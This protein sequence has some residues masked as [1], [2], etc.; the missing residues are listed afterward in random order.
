MPIKFL[1]LS[2]TGMRRIL[3]ASIA[4]IATVTSS[5]GEQQVTFFDMTSRAVS[6]AIFP[7]FAPQNWTRNASSVLR[8][9]VQYAG[10][11]LRP[12]TRRTR[13]TCA[14]NRSSRG[15]RTERPRV[16]PPCFRK[17]VQSLQ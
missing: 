17:A 14:S 15:V 12:L 1:W 9:F 16:F 6:A 3:V 2:V 10:R 13:T 7:P 4:L 11:V 5:S 8:S